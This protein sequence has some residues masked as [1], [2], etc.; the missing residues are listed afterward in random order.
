MAARYS[1]LAVLVGL[2]I[3]GCGDGEQAPQGSGARRE[4]QARVLALSTDNTANGSASRAGGRCRLSRGFLPIAHGN[5]H[6]NRPTK[7][8]HSLP[9]LAAH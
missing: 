1:L 5:R 9:H 4:S 3:V 2:V 8:T 7:G 6:S